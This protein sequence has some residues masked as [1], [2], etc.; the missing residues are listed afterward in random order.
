MPTTIFYPDPDPEVASVDGQTLE[1]DWG[2]LTWAAI[3][4]AP[5]FSANDLNP[6]MSF[7]AFRA[8]F[9]ANWAQLVR[10]I[11]LFDTSPLPDSSIITNAIFSLYGV[12]KLD[13]LGALP[14]INV[15]SSNPASDIALVAA[16]YA[17]LGNVAFCD[18]PISYAAWA[19]GYNDFILNAAGIAAISKTDRTK[20]GVRNVNRD[21]A[22]IA[23]PWIS[24]ARSR[25]RG[26]F[27]EQGGGF[28]PK[29]TVTY[30]IPIII[31]KSYALSREEL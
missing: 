4:A 5:G 25:L 28:R 7:V 10:S 8:A 29:L 14:D 30:S 17:T 24:L 27:T 23:P 31:N 6:F 22:G 9:A 3:R 16:D 1:E 2:G 12:D 18:T 21:V 20:M 13:E 11:F 15:Y 26:Y 19:V